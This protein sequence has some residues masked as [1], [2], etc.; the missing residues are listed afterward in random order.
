MLIPFQQG[1]G[2]YRIYANWAPPGS[3]SVPLPNSI[4]RPWTVQTGPLCGPE[5]SAVTLPDPGSFLRVN[6]F[7]NTVFD[8]AFSGVNGSEIEKGGLGRLQLGGDNDAFLGSWFLSQGELWAGNGA[9][10]GTLGGSN[11][12]VSGGATLVFNRS[13]DIVYRGDIAGKGTIRSS[14]AGRVLL[15]GDA[16]GFSG[17]V[18]VEN[19]QSVYLGDTVGTN[20]L[21]S[22]EGLLGLSGR[23]TYLD[24]SRITGAGRIGIED[25][26]TLS[27]AADQQTFAN[28]LVVSNGVLALAI[29]NTPP[30]GRSAS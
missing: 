16:S 22:N 14:G 18:A 27:L 28:E 17:T 13:D 6:E 3:S 20:A 19:G 7:T 30:T 11:I 9:T 15:T 5:G 24:A 4:L 29:T 1:A 26:A 12:Y 25:S 21:L 8:G 23:S 2:G 10:A